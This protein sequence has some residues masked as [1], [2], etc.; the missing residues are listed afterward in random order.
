MSSLA[1]ELFVGPAVVVDDEINQG[2]ASIRAVLDE[3]EGA[4]FPVMRRRD[5]PR[6]EEIGHWRAM[7]L[8]VVDWDL[9][10][11][12]SMGTADDG[13]EEESTVLGVALPIRLK[14]HGD[15]DT[16]RFVRKLMNELY[17][18]I[19]IVSNLDVRGI[20]M[21]LESGLDEA[22]IRALRARVFVRSKTGA[23]GSLLDSLS[24]W[25]AEH[26]AI[27]ALKTWE[28][29]YERAKSALFGDFQRSAAAW[30]GILWQTSDEDGVNP[31]HDLA[32]TI[33]R[34]LFHR[35]EPNVFCE[36]LISSSAEDS[37]IESVRSIL[38]QQSV[39]PSERLYDDVTMPG[40]FFFERCSGNRLPPTID[41]CLT[42][43]CDLVA[44]GE[45]PQQVEAN[46]NAMQMFMVRASLVDDTALDSKNKI[47]KMLKSS[48]STTSMLLH[49]LV[50]DDAMY[51][52]RFK[53]WF[54]TTWGEVKDRRRGRLLEPYITLLQQRNG[55]FSQRQGLPRLPENF[56]EPRPKSG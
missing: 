49:H 27:Y 40:D 13:S 38:H 9:R 3:L 33:S 56:Y 30:P 18:P 39:V 28:R 6:D 35:M 4:H 26:P 24:E 14:D 21:E 23:D 7:A 5:L 10:G 47:E 1:R 43:A 29:A 25:I 32:E 42:P 55:L 15:T 16:L 19:F 36:S 22:A 12:L 20:W 41:I 37:P 17:C 46:R 2:D 8:I 51:L 44:R 45:N 34:N 48:D 54:V 52:V 50:P 31:N 11:V 53:D